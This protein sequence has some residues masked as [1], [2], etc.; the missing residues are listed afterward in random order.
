MRSE[1]SQ[2]NFDLYNFLESINLEEYSSN[3]LD[4]SLSEMISLTDKDLE[5]LGILIRV[6]RLK[7][8]ESLQEYHNSQYSLS[9]TDQDFSTNNTQST[10]DVDDLSKNS[11]EKIMIKGVTGSYE[12]CIYIIGENGVK[13]G[14]GNCSDIILPDGYVSRKHCEIKYNKET[15]EFLLYDT[16]ST[17]GTYIKVRDIY[18]LKVG[19]LFQLGTCEFKVQNINYS[20]TGTPVSLEIVKYDGPKSM[21]LIIFYGGTIGRSKECNISI[22][23]DNMMSSIHANIFLKKN[24]FFLEDLN[25]CNKTWIRLSSEGEFSEEYSLSLND[26]IKI[27]T[28]VFVVQYFEDSFS[29]DLPHVCKKCKSKPII[30]ELMPCCHKAC[31]DCASKMVQCFICY[32][33]IKELIRI[34]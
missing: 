17:T 3:L 22:P 9:Y 13:I 31:M 14:R 1:S 33:F 23:Q 11:S 6:H 28:S 30:I 21:P 10:L 26:F 5:S 12:N 2:L 29:K 19:S 18:P 20:L 34:V 8:L 4:L 25:S 16:G 7:I 15:N 32:K 27:G 24:F